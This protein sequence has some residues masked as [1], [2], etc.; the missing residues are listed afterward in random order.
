[1]K[2]LI[3]LLLA[4]LTFVLCFPV[5][6]LGAVEEESLIGEVPGNVPNMYLDIDSGYSYDTIFNDKEA[7]I[8]A[9]VEIDGAWDSDYDLAST[10]VELK[11]RG[12][13]SFLMPKK[14]Y[15]IKFDKKTDLFG[16]GK[17]KKWVL[18]ANY[19]DGSF[20][21][22][23]IIYDIAENIGM[24]YTVKSVF[25]NL[26]IDGDYKGV[27]QLCEKVEIGD[28]RV[29]LED[30]FGVIAEMEAKTRLDGEPFYFFSSVTGKPFVYKEYNT[31]FEDA[32]AEDVAA[33]RAFF[34]ERMNAL[35][36][37]L[38]NNGKDWE[39]VKSLIDID[40]VIK[41]Y[42]INELCMNADACFSSTY[43]YI[44]GKDDI[45]HMGPVWDYDRCFGYYDY[46]GG[47]VQGTEEDFM[48]N[49]TDCT[50]TQRVEWYKM[51]F[52]YPEFVKRANELYTDV[53][54]DEIDPDRIIATIDA[55][56][57]LLYDSLMRNY[58]DEGWALFHNNSEAEFFS[59][60]SNAT[61]YLAFT[62]DYLK[63]NIRDR[64]AYL[65]SAYG[66]Y[67]PVLSYQPNG[68]R[69]YTGGS[70]TELSD[71][72]TFAVS[73]DSE[74]DGGISYTA[75]G[76]RATATE[77]ADGT[78]VAADRI[79]NI[80]VSLYGNVANYYSIQYRTMVDG[81]WSR[82]RADGMDAGGRYGSVISRVQMRLV[83]KNPVALGTVTFDAEG[84]E[85]VSAVVGN[86][87]ALPA[88]PEGVLGWYT[89]PEFEGEAVTELTVSEGE[90]VIY[91]K[92]ETVVSVPGDMNGDGEVN[93]IDANVMKRIFS[94]AVAVD[95]NVRN[96]GDLN[97]D[98][99]F[100]SLD[101][102]YLR[103]MISGIN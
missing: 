103:R 38:Y 55:Y 54:K 13:S 8:R 52:Q 82:W 61:E 71:M 30:D 56:Q 32:P 22:N 85:P 40:S 87:I 23:K 80:T 9:H 35:E 102:N 77:G 16:M 88:L 95:E 74:I 90:T 15:Q 1:M 31:D 64:V 4:F 92:R 39:L 76:T 43:F 48:K 70:M 27:Y 97:G 29:P 3:A 66:E 24:P 63:N 101:S 75:K 50:D 100:N 21:R 67:H 93:S 25:V 28:S 12:N 83:E 18:L 34:E 57:D 20:V 19:V 17:A 79:Y 45:L 99:A 84:V 78:A 81:T 49:I 47:Y 14:P 65:N 96:A 94:G 2:K 91:A 37:E 51:F 26:Y 72:R 60:R 11:T 69:S 46:N 36:N 41:F 53:I 44:D 73:L 62:T 58:V 6:A 98:G 10:G 68:G 33:V 42:F 86:K 5:G 89:T 59:S 7:K